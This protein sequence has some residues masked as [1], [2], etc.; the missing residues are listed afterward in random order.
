MMGYWNWEGL[1][2]FSATQVSLKLKEIFYRVVIRYA[3]LYE[4]ECWTIKN[5][6]ENKVSVIKMKILCRIYG[7]TGYD[8]I[9]NGNIKESDV[10]TLIVKKLWKI[11]LGIFD[12]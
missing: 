11:C 4:I 3:M 5:Q 6:P 10:V 1:H 8:K 7:K 2:G 12:M 9:R